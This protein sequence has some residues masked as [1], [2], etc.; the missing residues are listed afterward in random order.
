M[1]IESQSHVPD[2]D[3]EC[4]DDLNE[5]PIKVLWAKDHIKI[6]STMHASPSKL[7]EKSNLNSPWTKRLGDFT[8]NLQSPFNMRS[9]ASLHAPKLMISL[10]NWPF[11]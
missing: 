10:N 9:V 1:Y 8:R 6:H 11:S 3:E 4:Y 2:D 7:M 5:Q